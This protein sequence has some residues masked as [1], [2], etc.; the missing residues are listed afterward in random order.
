M[1][2]FYFLFISLYYV[3]KTPF[4][5]NVIKLSNDDN[6]YNID[7][8]LEE[9]KNKM[10]DLKKEKFRILNNIPG[11]KMINERDIDNYY[12]NN[13]QIDDTDDNKNIDNKKIVQIK[14]FNNN[15]NKN[16]KGDKSENFE[17]IKNTNVNFTNIGGYD[18]IKDEIM[19]CA[20]LL[21]DFNKY[22]KYNVRIPKG[23]ILEGPPGNGKTLIVKCF[24]GEINVSFIPVSGSQ[25]QEK[26]VGIGASRVREL[27]ALAT[28]NKPCIIFIDEIDAI[29]RKRSDNDKNVNNEGDTTLNELLVC[30]DGFKSTNGIFVIG[31]TN[32]LDL[33]DPALIR[34][35][36][37]DKSIYIGLPDAKTR[38]SIIN[39]HIKGKPHDSSITIE[40]LIEMTQGM[41]GSQ[42]E[43]LLNEAMLLALRS[44]R[45]IMTKTE[46][47]FIVNRILVGWQASQHI[48]TD[49]LLYQIAVHEMGHAVVG[50]LSDYNKLLK[51]SLNLWSPKTPG[52]TLFE[53]NNQNSLMNKDK[54]IIHLMVLLGGRIAEEEFFNNAISTGAS[55]DLE[56]A[57]DLAQNMIL[58]FGMGSKIIFPY[59]SDKSKEVVDAEISEIIN[60]AY[61][62]AKLIITNSK[63]LIDE[64][65]NVLSTEHV[66]TPEFIEKKINLKYPYLKQIIK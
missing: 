53:S 25:F 20:D 47:E 21:T 59:T 44:N 51:V 8:Q 30:L 62:K 5:K 13:K 60:I 19:Q 6:L 40:N 23:L 28:D 33:L 63:K 56:A 57:R 15:N 50:L 32:R 31:A 58:T 52:Y 54:L 22:D 64:C 24:S 29:G 4:Y 48:Y 45:E 41:S 36:R 35:G 37:I 34:P 9:L 11:L 18:L 1:N 10:K 27:F 38:E 61:N 3:K 16:D 55:A 43:N 66:L 14:F 26:Y 12:D 46:I 49:K 7:N 2:L 39:I 65:A 17:V 42:I